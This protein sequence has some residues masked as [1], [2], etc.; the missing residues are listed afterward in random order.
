M[1]R[2]QDK[3]MK[4]KK[5][6]KNKV[7]IESAAV[8]AMSL[9]LGMMP[10]GFLNAD[11]TPLTTD[12]SGQNAQ[13]T[14]ESQILPSPVGE[15]VEKDV[16]IEGSE[17]LP[18]NSS[19]ELQSD[20][21]DGPA[22]VIQRV[23]NVGQEASEE[24]SVEYSSEE[25]DQSSK[26]FT[27]SEFGESEFFESEAFAA[28]KG[29]HEMLQKFCGGSAEKVQENYEK[30]HGLTTERFME[31]RGLRK[32]PFYISQSLW[33]KKPDYITK[34]SLLDLDLRNLP[35]S[36]AFMLL[37]TAMGGEVGLDKKIMELNDSEFNELIEI[38][39][40]SSRMDARMDK[41]ADLLRKV[42]SYVDSG[43]GFAQE[44]ISKIVQEVKKDD[45]LKIK[46]SEV[47]R[48]IRF[49]LDITKACN[50]VRDGATGII[51]IAKVVN[52]MLAMDEYSREK[53]KW[54]ERD[55]RDLDFNPNTSDLAVAR[56]NV[57]KKAHEFMSYAMQ[58]LEVCEDVNSQV[59]DSELDLLYNAARFTAEDFCDATQFP[60]YFIDSQ[61]L[62]D[63]IQY[64][65]KAI[66][67]KKSPKSDSAIKG[68][69]PDAEVV[70]SIE[71]ALLVERLGDILSIK[72][73]LPDNPCDACERIDELYG[74]YSNG[75][76]AGP[77]ECMRSVIKHSHETLRIILDYERRLASQSDV[78]SSVFDKINDDKI[79]DDLDRVYF[80]MMGAVYSI[81]DAQEKG[82]NLSDSE[83][84]AL[85]SKVVEY[86]KAGYALAADMD[87]ILPPTEMDGLDG[88]NLRGLYWRFIGVP[89]YMRAMEDKII[90]WCESVGVNKGSIPKVDYDKWI[91]GN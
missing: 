71:D 54:S 13:G 17:I 76:S 91:I 64:L 74:K 56:K 12:Q 42:N 39:N 88:D 14:L 90:D 84:N 65:S 52:K 66:E 3:N 6:K 62:S 73:D 34:G 51:A 45:I 70:V 83:K 9:T 41:T 28:R 40:A 25:I 32:R 86:R 55:E 53:E 27:G 16:S 79:N 20:I 23:Y 75:W 61:P 19:K 4:S 11:N 15:S 2:N 30:I 77:E 38:A 50:E 57:Q 37:S 10:L 81:L 43:I 44:T 46:W 24:Y 67:A 26:A 36:N 1:S 58:I 87:K 31:M 35:N 69:K 85:I 80:V 82:S 7:G 18:E 5:G 60:A 49:G 47:G 78:Y 22:N 72:E 29:V 89:K 68:V 63:V 8:A 21:L 33:D 59:S 48:R